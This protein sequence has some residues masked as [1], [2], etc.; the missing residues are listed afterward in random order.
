MIQEEAHNILP[1]GKI[2]EELFLFHFKSNKIKFTFKKGNNAN[3]PVSKFKGFF[4][5][6]KSFGQQPPL[7]TTN[8]GTYGKRIIIKYIWWF[9]FFKCS[10]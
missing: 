3:T 6:S 7:G 8:T 10:V 5:R 2:K 4:S 1:E 9:I